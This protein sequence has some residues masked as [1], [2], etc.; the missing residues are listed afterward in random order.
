MKNSIL[1]KPPSV[2]LLYLIYILVD[3]HSVLRQPVA[4]A[5]RRDSDCWVSFLNPTYAAN[6]ANS[7]SEVRV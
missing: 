7:P 6:N 2:Y 1:R 3:I 5:T 4:W